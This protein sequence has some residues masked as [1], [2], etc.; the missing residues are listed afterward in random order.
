MKPI[1][2]F[3]LMSSLNA[4]DTITYHSEEA[5]TSPYGALDDDSKSLRCK[6]WKGDSHQP[7]ECDLLPLRFYDNKELRGIPIFELNN[8]GLF[9][10]GERKCN[11]GFMQVTNSCPAYKFVYENSRRL[12]IG[13]DGIEDKTP[14]MKYEGKKYYIDTSHLKELKVYESENERVGKIRQEIEDKHKQMQRTAARMRKENSGLKNFIAEMK[15][16]LPTGN[17]KCVRKL[18]DMAYGGGERMRILYCV[19]HGCPYEYVKSYHH[20]SAKFKE[21]CR[22]LGEGLKIPHEIIFDCIDHPS[23]IGFAADVPTGDRYEV[24]VNYWC[25]HKNIEFGCGLWQDKKGIWSFYLDIPN[26]WSVKIWGG[27]SPEGG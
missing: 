8:E 19:Q 14:V 6:Y 16:C 1:F 13:I 20:P 5:I 11:F 10:N 12:Y 2:L 26:E 4:A 24:G 21:C 15:Q 17:Y 25:K 18:M 22:S 9:H 7:T 27:W 23:R 3:L